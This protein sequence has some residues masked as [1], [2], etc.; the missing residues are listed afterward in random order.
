VLEAS[1]LER[2][3]I[4]DRRGGY[5]FEQNG[6]LLRMLERIGFDVT[7]LAARVVWHR[8]TAPPNPRTH[9]ALLVAIGGDRYLC[10]VG[11][12]GATQTMPLEF[13]IGNEQPT[14]HES[15]RIEQI[16]QGFALFIRLA[17]EWRALYEFDLQPQ[18]PIDYEAMNHYV[19]TWPG[20]IFRSVL[21]AG[22]PDATGRYALG[23]NRLSR[24]EKGRLV[25]Q[26]M[27]ASA[28]A[29]RSALENEL[30]LALPDDPGLDRVLTRVAAAGAI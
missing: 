30:A 6:L 29:L 10:D 19:Q 9:M 23:G 13:T 3:L 2:K 16:D 5:C 7:P 4:H 21:M 20:S 11:F 15:Y 28:A 14:T 22:R 26:R 27:L 8:D 24:Y 1:A 12:G 17:D 25:E 18:Q